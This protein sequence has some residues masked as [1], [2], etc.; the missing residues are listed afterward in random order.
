[1][2]FNAVGVGD[3]ASRRTLPNAQAILSAGRAHAA[4]ADVSN[5]G[6]ATPYLPMRRV[7]QFLR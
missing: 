5:G 4:N 3:G 6:L 1:M 7:F 2:E